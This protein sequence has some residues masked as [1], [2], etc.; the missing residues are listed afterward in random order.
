MKEDSDLPAGIQKKYHHYFTDKSQKICRDNIISDE[1]LFRDYSRFGDRKVDYNR[2]RNPFTL[3]KYAISNYDKTW[4]LKVA[5]DSEEQLKPHQLLFKISKPLPKKEIAKK[6]FTI[7]GP[8]SSYEMDKKFKNKEFDLKDQIGITKQEFFD[9]KYLIEIV[10][11]LPKIRNFDGM[12]ISSRR[13]ET[14]STMGADNKAFSHL[15]KSAQKF[16]RIYDESN[17][18]SVGFSQQATPF[19]RTPFKHILGSNPFE[20]P[21]KDGFIEVNN[22]L[23]QSAKKSQNLSNVNEHFIVKS[24]KKGFPRFP[25]SSQGM[26]KRKRIF[27]SLTDVKANQKIERPIQFDGPDVVKRMTFIAEEK[28]ED[29]KS[30]KKDPDHSSDDSFEFDI[31]EED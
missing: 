1:S 5:K 31:K 20:V 21:N 10:Y 4:Y 28:V 3:A 14:Q 30:I 11:P 6:E 8:F 23:L 22:E 15:F 25:K 19:K 27:T 12:S 29:E 16:N 17:K 13:N 7:E 18:G 26:N 24:W 9:F 2:V